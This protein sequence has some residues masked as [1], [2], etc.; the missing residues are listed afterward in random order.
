MN[1]M[2]VLL[3]YE[4]RVRCDVKTTDE[5]TQERAEEILRSAELAL[6]ADLKVIKLEA[7]VKVELKSLNKNIVRKKTECL[8]Q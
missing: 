2:H 3:S 7:R 4:S 1:N 8:A 6:D 5:L